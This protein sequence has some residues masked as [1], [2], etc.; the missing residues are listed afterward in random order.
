[1]DT[2][3]STG[4]VQDFEGLGFIWERML[5]ESRFAKHCVMHVPVDIIALMCL[6][7]VRVSWSFFWFVSVRVCAPSSNAK[8]EPKAWTLNPK[9]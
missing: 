5:F 7:C 3:V 9:P 2:T 4:F 1:M 8:L 6:V